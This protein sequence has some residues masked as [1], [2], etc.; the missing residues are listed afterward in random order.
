M[1]IGVAGGDHDVVGGGHW[2]GAESRSRALEP[3]FP[4][5]GHR[6]DPFNRD[7]IS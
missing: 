5:H 2:H 7:A 1:H 4:C 6:N 3:S